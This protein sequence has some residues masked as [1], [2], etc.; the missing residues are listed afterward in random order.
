MPY[1]IT[2]RYLPPDTSERSP[3]NPSHADWYSIYL[4][5]RDGRLSWPSWLD[6]ASA[7]SRTSDLS[8]NRCTTKI[9]VLE[10][11]PPDLNPVDYKVRGITRS[12]S[13][14]GPYSTSLIWSGARLLQGLACSSTSSTRQLTSSVEWTA[15]HLCEKW[16]ATRGTFALII[17]IAVNVTW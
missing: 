14:T 7:G 1:G 8:M 4:P 15:V 12:V 3:A 13:T 11:W 16:W 10:L 9:T 6:S 5:Q 17:W 2:Q